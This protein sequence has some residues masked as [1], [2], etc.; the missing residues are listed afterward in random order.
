[1]LKRTYV[2]TMRMA[3]VPLQASG[4]LHRLQTAPRNSF[5]FWLGS[6]FAIYDAAQLARMDV[7]WWSFP[8]IVAVEK[9]LAGRESVR[10]F[11]YGS[12]ASTAWLARRCRHVVSA[13][14]DAGF[15]H[16][17]A[18]VIARDNIELRLAEPEPSPSPLAVSGR[19]GFA[20]CDFSA[21]VN[22]IGDARYDLIVI[23]GRARV[24]CLERALHQLAHGGVI[25]FDNSNRRRYADALARVQ[26]PLR[27]YRGWAPALPYRS[28]T[29]LIGDLPQ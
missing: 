13:E 26:L 25:V 3:A 28:E 4:L 22:M 18:P 27:R 12:G 5:R 21:Y 16:A 6:Q 7:P 20:H 23:D 14:H 19:K 2:G 1:M 10:A 8:A 17:I 29:T 24:A 11:E 9:W 15:L